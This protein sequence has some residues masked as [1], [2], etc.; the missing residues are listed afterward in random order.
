MASDKM[1]S[2][3]SLGFHTYDNKIRRAL[4]LLAVQLRDRIRNKV[5]Y[6]DLNE[7]CATT[8][9]AENGILQVN[10]RA[11]PSGRPSG[12]GRGGRIVTNRVDE[13]RGRKWLQVTSSDVCHDL[14]K[15]TTIYG[16]I[17]CSSTRLPPPKTTE[18]D[19][20]SYFAGLDTFIS[21]YVDLV[22]R[23]SLTDKVLTDTWFLIIRD[24]RDLTEPETDDS[25]GAKKTWTSR[26]NHMEPVKERRRRTQ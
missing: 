26:E 5:V 12:G 13:V 21:K 3:M 10:R 6:D 16:R 8:C 14:L 25:R 2:I 15:T 18:F 23:K 17:L 7:L 11:N 24:R 20:N 9:L 19:K 22:K 4:L 1:R